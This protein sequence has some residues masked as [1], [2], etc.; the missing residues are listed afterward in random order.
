VLLRNQCRTAEAALS[1]ALSL[2]FGSDKPLDRIMS[3]FFR[4]HKGAGSKDRRFIGEA[5]YSVMRHWGV[6][7]KLLSSEYREAAEHGEEIHA[8]APGALIYAA[9]QMDGADYP[10]LAVFQEYFRYRF[11]AKEGEDELSAGK[12]LFAAC[13][14]EES[15]ESRDLFYPELA[16]MLAPE[17]S[18]ESV[19]HSLSTRPPL[20]LRA[21]GMSGEELVNKLA[22]CEVSASTV[23]GMPY[24][25]KVPH[26]PVN[27]FALELYRKGAFEMQDLSSQVIGLAAAPK[28]GERWL[29][30]CAGAGGKTLQ[31]ADLMQRK[32]T[33]VACDIRS[34]KLD[35]L[36]LRARRA[37]FPNIECRH[38]DGGRIPRN[39][40]GAFDG[41]LVD[42]PC[43]CSGVWRRNPDGRWRCNPKQVQEIAALQLSILERAAAAVKPDGVLVY[44]TCSL[45]KQENRDI[46]KA[47]LE[48]N[49]VFAL[50][51]FDDP[52]GLGK[53]AGMLQMTMEQCDSDAMFVA[54]LRHKG[55]C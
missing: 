19:L 17:F 44:A 40:C 21:Q 14:V 50:E 18:P 47:F 54:R 16:Q 13:R 9:L 12:R 30:F 33:V 26:T 5:V 45:F 11:H 8:P 39:W 20:Y 10:Q 52:R 48:K 32:G 38:Y 46:V 27:L 42:A 15:L 51:S 7:R 22:A 25:V 49:P 43:S 28:K 53:T 6:V 37:G 41:V 4:T 29:D 3:G 1:E 2:V 55:G 31:L 35:D 24:T 23:P 36:R 34:Y